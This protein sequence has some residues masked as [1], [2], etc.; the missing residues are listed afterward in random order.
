MLIL[1]LFL[2]TL[3]RAQQRN[4]VYLTGDVTREDGS[5]DKY[6]E[7]AYSQFIQYINTDSFYD[8]IAATAS[9]PVKVIITLSD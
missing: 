9:R 8:V 7:N 3:V 5:V 6:S 1:V 2:G 4:V